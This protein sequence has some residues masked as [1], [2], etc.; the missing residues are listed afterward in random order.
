MLQEQAVAELHE[1]TED[2]A[3]NVKPKQKP[4]AA[5]LQEEAKD[6]V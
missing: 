1:E 3:A 2:E 6:K 5:E 4:V